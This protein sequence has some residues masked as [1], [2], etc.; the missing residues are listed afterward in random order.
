[1]G[2]LDREEASKDVL[3]RVLLH[4]MGR[5]LGALLKG[6]FD[7]V[8]LVSRPCCVLLVLLLVRASALDGS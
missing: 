7:N 3:A 4:S 6:R 5:E 8:L 2:L 1:M